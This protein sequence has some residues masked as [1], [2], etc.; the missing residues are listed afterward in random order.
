VWPIMKLDIQH[1][2]A[3]CALVADGY[4]RPGLRATAS[5]TRFFNIVALLPYDLHD[6]VALRWLGCSGTVVPSSRKA[7]RW[8]PMTLSGLSISSGLSTRTF[9]FFLDILR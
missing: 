7:M 8:G 9:D 2:I 3:L 5:I 1:L 6:M 4:K